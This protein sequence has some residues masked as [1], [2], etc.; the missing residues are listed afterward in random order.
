VVDRR[1]ITEAKSA[2]LKKLQLVPFQV[3]KDQSDGET[4]APIIPLDLGDA[5]VSLVGLRNNGW[6][7]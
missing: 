2:I 6:D 7:K 5:V 3:F 4:Y 1:A